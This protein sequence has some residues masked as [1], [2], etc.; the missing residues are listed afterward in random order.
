LIHFP[1]IKKKNQTWRI[2]EEMGTAVEETSLHGSEITMTVRQ[3]L[4]TAIATATDRPIAVEVGEKR[5]RM[6]EVI[7]VTE[8]I[9]VGIET[10]ING[11]S[12]IQNGWMNLLKRKAKH[13]HR[14]ISR[15]GK[16]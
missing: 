4:E 16:N 10:E 6:I 7:E 14:K 1:A 9:A 8:A 3:L 15:N 11:R 2:L 5:I 13:I 12:V